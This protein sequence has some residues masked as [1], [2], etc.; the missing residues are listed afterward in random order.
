MS[1]KYAMLGFVDM[2]PMSGYD[3][4][5]LFNGSVSYFW[6][7][8]HSQ[9]YRTLNKMHEEGLVDVEVIIQEDLPNRK[10]YHITENGKVSLVKWVKSDVELSPI[11][12]RILVQLSWADCLETDEIIS[13]LDQY[14]IILKNRLTI[15]HH[16]MAHKEIF[17]QGRSEREI[18]LWKG[19][20][21]N[22]ILTYEAEARWAEELKAELEA[23]ERKKLE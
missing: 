14:L 10:V 15:Y 16:R 9:I 7:A 4:K 23:Y 19:T 20:L 1:L 12:N 5:T 11:K 13:L 18:I 2:Q 17:D 3:L 22:G 6:A 21:Q 8:T